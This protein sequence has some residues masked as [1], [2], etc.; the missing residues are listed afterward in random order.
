MESLIRDHIID[1]FLSNNLFSDSQYGFIRKRSTTLQLL[2][3]LDNWTLYLE[4]GQADVIYTDCE[5]AFDK[6]P[7][8]RLTSNLDSH[9]ID[10]AVVKWART[11][12]LHRKYR[13]RENSE[14]LDFM[15]VI[16]GILQGSGLGALLF[17]IYIN[18]SLIL[19]SVWR[20]DSE[21][22]EIY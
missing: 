3:L 8:N 18:D 7:H 13:V 10:E 5:K 16:S 15:P 14:Y 4:G 9:G 6:V 19:F 1:Y 17:V 2:K 12:L 22:C 20:T 11:F 21:R